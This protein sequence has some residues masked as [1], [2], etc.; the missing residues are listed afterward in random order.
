MKFEFDLQKSQVN[1]LKHGVDFLE[2]QQMW[3]G[4]FVEFAARQDFENRFAI[5]GPINGKI[6]TCIYTLRED[7]IRI[8]SCRRAR[9]KEEQLYAKKIK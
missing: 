7:A 6:H 4:A 8:I 1:K 9:D 2:A 5:I 3:E